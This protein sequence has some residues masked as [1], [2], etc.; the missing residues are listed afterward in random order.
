MGAIDND[1]MF[2]LTINVVIIIIIKILI[3]I[4]NFLFF[5]I[6]IIYFVSFLTRCINI[7]TP[8]NAVK[9]PIGVS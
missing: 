8:N 4:A 1:P 7:G 9:D 3:I 6:F 5:I 2:R